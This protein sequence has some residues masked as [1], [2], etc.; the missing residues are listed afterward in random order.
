MMRTILATVVVLACATLVGA[1]APKE[2][3]AVIDKAIKAAGGEEKLTKFQAH[4]WKAKG[5]YYGMGDGLPYT[6]NYAVQFPNKFKV[7]IE[8]VFTIVLDGDKGWVKSGD[9]TNEMTKEQLEEHKHERYAGLVATLLPLKDK[10]YKLATLGE[11]KVGDRPAIGIKVSHPGQR[12]VDLFFDKDNG[13]LV[14][15]SRKAKAEEQGGKEVTQDSYYSDYKDIE[16]AQFPCK[17]VV[18]RDDKVYVEA[19]NSDIK[20]AGKALPDGTFDKP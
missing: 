7:E 10:G 9:N 19:E 16:G 5:T 6:A 12:D 14:K 20:P 17:I 15:C 13:L 4:T 1:E 11:V 3:R 2:A 8:N 18:K